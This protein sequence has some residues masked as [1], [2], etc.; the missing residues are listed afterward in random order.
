MTDFAEI[1]VGDPM[2]EL[3]QYTISDIETSVRREH[4][5]DVL[6][7]YWET[8]TDN[9]VDKDEFPFERLIQLYKTSLDR[10]IAMFAV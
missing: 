4:E 1:G 6:R 5:Q 9:G 10:Y 8:L 2:S 7:V 3:V